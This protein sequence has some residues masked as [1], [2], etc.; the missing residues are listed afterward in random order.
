[1]D[2]GG[3]VRFGPSAEWPTPLDSRVE[4]FNQD[5]HL[6]DH[7]AEAVQ[8]YLPGLSPE[9]FVPAGV[10]LRPRSYG[11]NSPARDFYINEESARGLSGLVNLIGIESPGLTCA[12]AIGRYVRGIL[13][14]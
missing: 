5:F 3:Q 8:T 2:L 11:P 1:M 10:G 14:G 12:P 4:D 7:F 6:R 9:G 13:L